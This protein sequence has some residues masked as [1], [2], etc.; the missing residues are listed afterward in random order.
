MRSAVDRLRMLSFRELSQNRGRILAGTVVVAVC[1]ALLVTV[2]CIIASINRSIDDAV[3][4]VGGDARLEVTASSDAGLPSSLTARLDALPE[5]AHAVPS[6]QTPVVTDTAGTLLMVGVDATV[7]TLNSPLQ[8]EFGTQ[9]TEVLRTPGGVLAGPGTGLAAGSRLTVDGTAVTVAAVPRTGRAQR[10]NGGR[11]LV[12]PLQLTQRLAQRGDVVDSILLVPT[13]NTDSAALRSAAN[14][15][16]AGRG[17]VDAPSVQKTRASNGVELIRYVA[18]SSAALTFV[19]AAFLIYVSTSMALGSRRQRISTLRA[20]GGT[21][22]M[23]VGDLLL[24]TAFVSLLGALIGVGL[25]W[26]LARGTIERLPALFLQSAGTRVDFAFPFWVA[27]VAVVTATGVCVLAAALS[28]RQV[29]QVSPV[30]ALA[31]LGVTRPSRGLPRTRLV[32]AVLA[33]VLFIAALVAATRQPGILANTG[34]TVMFAAQIAAGLALS[35][36]I[37]AV[38]ARLA[39]LAGGAG[40]L[41]GET[42]R[43]TPN[44][45]WAT[46]MTVAVAVA[47]TLAISA[48][49]SNAVDST[50]D[51]FA[52]L[53]E[54]DVWVSTTPAGQFPTGPVLPSSVADRVL[55]VPG[56]ADVIEEQARYVSVGDQRALTYGVAHGAANPLLVAAD[57]ASQEAVLSGRG[58]VLSRDI[59]ESLSVAVG[60]SVPLTTPGGAKR[61]RVVAVVPFFSALNGAMAVSQPLM[62]QMFG[63]AGAST[64]A[65]RLDED[66]DIG[67]VLD[68]VRAVLPPGAH[69]YTGAAAVEAFGAALDQ[70]TT[71]NHLIWVIVTIIAGVALLNTLLLSVMERRRE[72]AALRA[73]GS[74]RRF[75]VGTVAAE[76]AAIGVVGGVLGVG[77]GIVQ[78]AVADLA[79]SRAWSVDVQFEVMPVSLAL[80]AGALLLCVSGA[81]PAALRVSRLNIISAMRVE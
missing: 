29:Y 32:A 64:L 59:A 48:G 25:G 45:A 11:Y 57:D 38:A 19:V 73:I 22:R 12:A 72:L 4:G 35:G 30:E 61:V 18:L 13:H 10:F 7:M 21:P 39:G 37:V 58:V 62:A 51:S 52:P 80:A 24:D 8:S 54:A 79:S 55:A 27:P 46:L 9:A 44:R 3:I 78:Q 31:P 1:T 28:A 33:P 74:S 53:R 69:A 20:L 34:I 75:V 6:V 68:E 60:D 14:R 66:V 77:F 56:V 70:A 15:V 17:L 67:R 63:N 76:A 36:P 5:V 26:L 23:I 81:I 16:V 2:L 49:N 50:K 43:R 71:L 65:V 41:A 40:V 47:A 42:I